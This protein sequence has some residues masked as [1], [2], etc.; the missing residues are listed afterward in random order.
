ML[1]PGGPDHLG[2]H[3]HRAGAPQGVTG[4]TIDVAALTDALAERLGHLVSNDEYLLCPHRGPGD[5]RAPAAPDFDAIRSEV[6]A[7][8][9]DAYLDKETREIVPS[10][11]GVDFDTAQ[12]QAVLDAA[13]EG[14]TVSVPCFSPSRS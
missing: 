14:E 6:A 5:H 12:A 4:R 1:R 11:T 13:G 3:R 8:P 7:E 2:G 9:A 10:V